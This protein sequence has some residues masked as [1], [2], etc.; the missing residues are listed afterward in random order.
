MKKQQEEI[1]IMVNMDVFLERIRQNAKWGY[2]RHPIGT[3]LAIL[4]EEVGEVAQAA[5]FELGLVSSKESDAS[6]LYE[7]LIHVS[8]VAAAIA[9]QVKEYEMNHQLSPSI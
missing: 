7:E 2:Q 5:Q 3:W 8:A 6:N 4:M 1:M 9:E